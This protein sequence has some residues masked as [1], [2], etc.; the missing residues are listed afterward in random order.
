MSKD[1]IV[2]KKLQLKIAER[3][4]GGIRQASNKTAK[5]RCKM[6]IAYNAQYAIKKSRCN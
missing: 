3:V 1:K 2:K 6:A 4:I 5:I